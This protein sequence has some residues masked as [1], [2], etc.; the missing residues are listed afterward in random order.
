MSRLKV[1]LAPTSDSHLTL[2][3]WQAEVFISAAF[4]SVRSDVQHAAVQ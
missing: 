3:N 1:H 2:F 4:H